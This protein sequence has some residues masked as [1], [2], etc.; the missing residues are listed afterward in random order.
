MRRGGQLEPGQLAMTAAAVSIKPE[1]GASYRVEDRVFGVGYRREAPP[2]GLGHRCCGDRAAL[3]AVGGKYDR[4]RRFYAGTAAPDIFSLC[5]PRRMRRSYH[6]NG[7]V[8]DAR[9]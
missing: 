3:G 6:V 2:A 8:V 4:T 9:F 5:H 1:A 7:V